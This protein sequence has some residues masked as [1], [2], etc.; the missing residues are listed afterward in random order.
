MRKLVNSVVSVVN[1]FSQC[2]ISLDNNKLLPSLYY[3]NNARSYSIG[4]ICRT[5][6]RDFFEAYIYNFLCKIYT[7]FIANLCN[8]FTRRDIRVVHWIL[9]SGLCN[10]GCWKHRDR[11]VCIVLGW[12][13]SS[14]EE[15]SMSIVVCRENLNIA[16]LLLRNLV[17]TWAA[18]AVELKVV[19]WRRIYNAVE[20]GRLRLKITLVSFLRDLQHWAISW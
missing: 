4:Y 7:Q 11:A 16:R 9:G 20:I 19:K 18:L 3:I 17:D 12:N 13:C 1:N 10:T 15:M 2:D 6:K 5:W 8:I 14:S